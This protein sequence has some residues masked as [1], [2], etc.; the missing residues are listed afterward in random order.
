TCCGKNVAG[1]VAK[2]SSARDVSQLHRSLFN[3]RTLC[4]NG[5][6]GH[7]SVESRAAPLRKHARA[8]LDHILDLTNF[9]TPDG[10]YHESMDYQ[11]ITFA[12][13]AMMAE[14]LRTTANS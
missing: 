10:G 5:I 1:P 12:P 6:E 11:R 4:P 14:L 8:V 2:R 7:A 3:P 9:I 13:L